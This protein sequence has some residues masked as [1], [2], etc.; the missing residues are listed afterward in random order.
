MM[1]LYER[2]GDVVVFGVRPFKFVALF[3]PDAN[4]Y[5]LADHPEN[6]RWREALKA[7]IP[8][9]GDTALVVSDGP[10]HKRR[11]RL[12]QP[13][14]SVANINGYARVMVDE[15]DA[16]LASWTPGR[17]LD[18]FTELRTVIRRIAVRSLF[19]DTLRARADEL[20]DALA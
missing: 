11:R 7:L 9:D 3:G 14:F 12:V 17:T 10:E 19:G 6:F 13:A 1:R 15:A 2:Y 18:A 5:I 4:R 20:G 8:I 16:G